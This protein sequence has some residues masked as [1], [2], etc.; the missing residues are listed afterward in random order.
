MRARQIYTETCR[1][2]NL[3]S[4]PLLHYWEC[5][6][7]WSGEADPSVFT[8]VRLADKFKSNTTDN[9]SLYFLLGVISPIFKT[10]KQSLKVWHLIAR[11][12][13]DFDVLYNVLLKLHQNYQFASKSFGCSALQ[14]RSQ[15]GAR[16]LS[17]SEGFSHPRFIHEWRQ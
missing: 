11:N 13:L 5:R 8:F 17:P 1:F 6:P 12:M 16:G 2:V 9:R 7:F 14:P 4:S 15:P 10:A 3:T